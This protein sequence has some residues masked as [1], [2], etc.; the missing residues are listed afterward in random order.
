MTRPHL[1]LVPSWF[2]VLPDCPAAGPVAD[3]LYDQATCATR[4]PSGRP[5]MLG[6]WPTA[7]FAVG[8]RGDTAI[9]VVGEHLLSDA[10]LAGAAAR[11]H[12]S[13]DLDGPARS[14]SGNFHLIASVS[15]RTR[16]QAPVSGFRRL[17]HAEV[18]GVTVAADRADVLA[19]LTGAA[20]D[21]TRLAVMLLEPGAPYPIAG[22]P[23]W[24]G[25][26]AVPPGFFLAVDGKGNHR[27]VRWWNAPEPAVPMAA[28]AEEL[29][30]ALSTAVEVRTHGRELVST[31]LGGVDTTSL[32]CLASRG[33]A[34]VVAYTWA[35]LD[36]GADDAAWAQR[37]IS[38]LG[39]VE[40]HVVPSERTPFAFSGIGEQD[41]V[42]LDEP[43][44]ITLDRRWLVI[45]DR[46][47]ARGSRL[48]L[49]GFGGDQVLGGSVAHLHTLLRRRPW[50]AVRNLR[51]YVALNRWH[52]PTVLRQLV[53]NRSY[54]DWLL[55]FAAEVTAPPSSSLGPSFYWAKPVRLPPWVMPAAATAVRDL[56]RHTAPGTE[57]LG[58]GHGQHQE[59]A[60]L[61]TIARMTRNLGVLARQRGITLA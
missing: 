19:A 54:Q 25:L 48:H 8:V 41:D 29:R 32:C 3:M 16:V 56:I 11:V 47:A 15:G 42:P 39:N 22:E 26:S 46:A 60:D 53:D 44:A 1:D 6:R 55:R 49:T 31:D 34:D 40:H 21:E 43:C 45:A 59:L 58:N 18:D 57:P 14:W 28:G 30:A 23:M 27:L 35:P 33:P 4:H 51:G 2:V 17:I 13:G 38:A 7:E 20:L 61:G 52:Y 37:T 10:A 36:S 12:T 9:A 50:T 24:H 5:W